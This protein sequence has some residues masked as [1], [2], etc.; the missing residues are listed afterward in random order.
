ME[1]P[2]ELTAAA[3]DLGIARQSLRRYVVDGRLPHHRIGR[4]IVIDPKIWADWKVRYFRG[5]FD[6]RGER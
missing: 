4:F 3:A 1:I 5:D 6:Q 2:I